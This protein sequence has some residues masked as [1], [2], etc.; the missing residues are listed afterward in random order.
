MP[1]DVMRRLEQ[2]SEP[3]AILDPDLMARILDIL[4]DAVVV[5]DEQ[6]I[7]RLVNQATELLFG[8]PRV[9]LLGEPLEKLLPESFRERHIEHRRRFFHEPRTRP[10]G[11]GIGRPLTGLNRNGT[12][13]TLEINLS[14]I[15]TGHGVYAVAVVR[16]RPDHATA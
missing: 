10:M 11:V 1:D 9:N 13:M 7:V 12:E 16:R 15:V 4:P 2:L 14:P 8:Y 6:G 5:I 3:G